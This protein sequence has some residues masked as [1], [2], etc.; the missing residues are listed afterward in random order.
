VTP[1]SRENARTSSEYWG[2]VWTRP[3][4]PRLPSRLNVSTRNLQSVLRPHVRSG[5]RV[6]EIG[7]APGKHLAWVASR[8]GADIAGIDYAAPGVAF[9]RHLMEQLG[10]TAD[11]RCESL[12]ET[13]F[14]GGSFDV[15]YSAGVIEHF[16]DPTPIVR[17]HVELVR[18][19]GTC[20]ITIPNYGRLY[21][22]I[23]GW[24]DP[25]NLSIHNTAIM[26]PAVL[27]ELAPKDLCA[28]IEVSHAGRLD[29]SLLSVEQRLPRLIA[30]AYF[31]VGQLAG[32]LQLISVRTLAPM[33]VLTMRRG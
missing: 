14:A 13:S 27:A 25:E 15:V 3:P 6:L 17:R 20:V 33:L 18:P 1:H 22:R 32:A 30:S 5:D 28:A 12:E 9:T 31:A 24:L 2:D 26:E 4:R 8:L 29:P 23:Q 10:I 19:G 16:D 7:C 21:G 11:I